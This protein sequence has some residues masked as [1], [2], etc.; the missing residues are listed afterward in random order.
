MSYYTARRFCCLLIDMCLP[1]KQKLPITEQTQ[2]KMKT[3]FIL[4]SWLYRF[5]SALAI[6]C[7]QCQPSQSEINSAMQSIMAGNTIEPLCSNPTKVFDCSQ[8]P[9]I[10]FMPDSCEAVSITFNISMIGE[11]SF[12][13]LNC[14][15]KSLCRMTEAMKCGELK[16]VF[17]SNPGLE[18]A[19]CN[20]SCCEGEQCNG[21]SKVSS[22]SASQ[23]LSSTPVA[24]AS[25]S[26]TRAPN[27]TVALDST[28][29]PTST[30]AAKVP[31]NSAIFSTVC[32]IY[33]TITNLS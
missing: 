8:D 10:G 11:F 19:Q 2:D 33:L 20:V 25:P 3:T 29:A 9:N 23:G 12:N 30:A 13:I 31:S 27:S 7:Y 5:V 21:P 32:L 1:C 22:E 26:S 16:S 28:M 4:L 14:S 24:R 17:Q 6:H 18:L 15:V